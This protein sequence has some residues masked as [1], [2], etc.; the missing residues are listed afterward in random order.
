M[1]NGNPPSA[2]MNLTMGTGSLQAP[3]LSVQRAVMSGHGRGVPVVSCHGAVSGTCHGAVSGTC[4]G[5]VYWDT[6]RVLGYLPCTGIL[7]V[8][9]DT[10]RVL[11]SM[12]M[13]WDP[14]ACT[15]IHGQ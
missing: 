15:G 11:G 7:A 6:C 13:Y 5:A 3:V 12:G 2:L 9:W 10:S 1:V 14:W 8:Y 4:H